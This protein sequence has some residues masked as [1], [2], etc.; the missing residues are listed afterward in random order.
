MLDIVMNDEEVKA[1]INNVNNVIVVNNCGCHGMGHVTRVMNYVKIILS[2]IG[3]D[4]HTIM[5]G[6]IAA[7]LHDVGAVMG[8]DGHA[9]RSAIFADSFLS[10]VGFSDDDKLVIVDAIKN[11]SKGSS[12]IIGAALTFADKIDMQKSRMMRFIDGNYFHDNIKHMLDVEVSV[13]D[14][15]IVVNIV[16]DGL[17]DYN[18]LKDYSKMITKPKEMSFYLGRECVFSIDGVVVDLYS[19]VNEKE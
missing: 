14:E 18:S 12:S 15:S 19:I 16:T 2:G 9:L 6:M 11:H 7:Y 3:C 1:I 13:D 10:R 17:F 8:K 4:D 5:L